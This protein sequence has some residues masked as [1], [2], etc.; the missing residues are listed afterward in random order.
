M[1]SN[2][3]KNQEFIENTKTSFKNG[4]IILKYLAQINTNV[5]LCN[6]V[7][8]KKKDSAFKITVIMY[9]LNNDVFGIETKL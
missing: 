1:A 2:S 7:Y 4:K 5:Y 3:S 9:Y 6:Y 8:A